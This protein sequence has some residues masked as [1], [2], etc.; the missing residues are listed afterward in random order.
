[1]SSQQLSTQEHLAFPRGGRGT[2]PPRSVQLFIVR[3]GVVG[4]G[5]RTPQDLATPHELPKPG[6]QKVEGGGEGGGGGP[7]I[8]SG[9]GACGGARGRSRV[10]PGHRRLL[11]ASVEPTDRRRKAIPRILGARGC[12]ASTTS[13]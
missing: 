12:G 13:P 8:G 11:F 3:E 4:E 2:R 9:A 6:I 7:R 5:E 10:P 1:M